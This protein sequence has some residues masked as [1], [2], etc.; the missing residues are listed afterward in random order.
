ME[1]NGVEAT[2]LE[3]STAMGSS[4]S[5]QDLRK[6]S[7]DYDDDEDDDVGHDEVELQWAAI[8][9]LPTFKRIR[10]S[11]FDQ[12]LLNAGKDEVLGKKVIN[13]TRLG[14][15]ERRVFIDHLITI[16]DKDNLKLLK[17]LKERMARVGLEL[18][19]TDVR[20]KNLNVEAECKVVHG[21]PH[22][23][24]LWNTIT[25]IFS[26]IT[27]VNRCMSQPNKIKI[28]NDVSGIVKPSRMTLLLGLPGCGKTTFLQT[29]AGKHD[30]SLKVSGEISYN[31]YKL[32]EFVPQKTSAYINQY[33]LHISDMT[34]RETIDF[35][36]RCQGIGSRADILKELS[37]RE[38][39]LGIIPEPDLDTY[40]KAISVEG[41]KRTLQTD[42]ILKILGLDICGDT[43]VGDAM[44]RGI[45]GGEK[46]RLTIGEMMVGPTIAFFMDEISTG[47]DS[48]TTFQ[49]VT[50]LQQLAHVIGAT[51]LISLLQPTPET[52]D[53]FD[54]IIL[55]DEGKIVYNGPKSDVQEFFEYC[56][57]K[58]PPRKGLADF[59]LEVLSQ[60]DQAQYWFH[61][62]QPHSYVSTDKFIAAFKEFLAGQRLNE[63]LY[64]P[65]KIT[66]DHK[67]ALSFNIYSFEKWELFKACLTREWLLTKR[68]SFL[69]MFRSAQLVS[70]S[71]IVVTLFIRTQMKIDEFHARKY[72]ACLFF[73]LLR[74]LTSGVPE[75]ALTSSRLGIFYKQRDLYF[76]P[77]WAYSIPSA[78]LRIPFS[79]LD[80]FIWTSLIYFGV[81]YSPEPER[82][83][84]QLFI[85]FLLHQVGTSIFRLI[86]V[87]IQTPPVAA[88]F[89]QF[90]VMATLLSSGFIV[91][92]PSMPSWIKWCFW[93]SPL[94]HTDIGISVNEFLSP[95]W[96]KVS[97]LNETLGH[98]ALLKRGLNFNKSSYW[99]SVSTLIG[100]WVLAN[101]GFTLALSYSKPPGTGRSRAIVSHKRFSYLKRKEDLSNSMQDD[102]LQGAHTTT[103]VTRMVL[104]FVPVTLSFDNVHYFV[105][106][107]K[108][109]QVPNKKLHLLQDIS[110]AFRPGV[111]T[112]L[113]GSSGAGKTTLMDVLSGR[114]TG[115][116]I[117]GDIR[118]GGYPKVREAYARVFGYCEQT[119]VHS[120][121]I[122]V[123]E[124]VMYSAWLRLPAEIP[125]H[126]RLIILMKRGGQIIYSGELGQNSCNLIEYFEGIPGVSKIK[127]NYNPATWMLEVTNPSVEAELGVDFAHL[128]KESHLY[129]RN[130]K[131]VN[132]LRV[133]T[134]GLEE[135]HFTTHFSQNR[136]EQFKTCLWKQHLSY[137]RNPT[138][139]LGRLILAMVSS[140]LYGA[141]LWNKGQKVDKDQDLFNIMGSVYVFTISIGASNLLSILPI[142]TSQRTIMYRE[143]FA[144]MYP[145]KAH[146]LAQVIIEIP[147][148]FLEATL[149]LII[150]YPAVNLYESAYKVSWYFYD[151][152]CTLLNYKYMG[153]AIASLSSTYQMA[154]ICGSFCIT[155]VNLFSGFLIPQ[156]MLPKWWVW[157]YWIIP[158]SWTLRGLITSQYG[159]INREI[160]AF[161]K[162]KTITAFLKSHYGFKHEDMLLTAILLLAY[163]IFFASIFT[164]FTAKLNFQRR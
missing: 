104:P 119:D 83:F 23:P 107:P 35:S 73:G 124:S 151:I 5:F 82:F 69:Y 67:N 16:I 79:F 30:P 131:L 53:L 18:P 77:A 54:D 76:Y 51:I 116:Y 108:K 112:A 1:K 6:R 128:Y 9:R 162:R 61:R 22:I 157:F 129:Q 142:V 84:R 90:T 87:V 8:E 60:K 145:S 139:N 58:C 147:Y 101:I 57:F 63:E 59:L 55:M 134:Q 97:S 143:R 86:A 136:W 125:K 153:M 113:M 14:A 146:S 15:L 17:K 71:L 37:R 117:E 164:F 31:G 56:G 132:E 24:T 12:K 141:L 47:L 36:A 26:A 99:I 154:S 103:E 102:Q 50:C 156:P 78:I 114:K 44:S 46:K 33:D 13:V 65:F 70:L 152:F 41:L 96:Q 80:T 133:P 140:L 163:P 4:T 111:L 158:T 27:N 122:T 42:Y 28:L 109:F 95:R 110:G 106:T 160:I 40:M 72:M 159:D 127:E 39:F 21:K 123:K 126:I 89:C 43:I 137:W 20:F 93:I 2:E 85:Q 138:Y 120:P 88:I 19:T 34:V 11:L 144:G 149:F 135:L 25:N 48:S 64:A 121:Q 155:V 49:I 45:S 148:I 105:D 115:G 118:V 75:L 32:S 68:N 161:G 3:R 7:D 98:R 62:D 150:S 29:L 38:K 94:S 130:K 52:V 100:M 74:I 91:P 92:L 66:E 10:T 81:G